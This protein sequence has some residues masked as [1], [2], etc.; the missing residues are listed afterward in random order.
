MDEWHQYTKGNKSA[1]K[2][3]V[4]FDE[5]FIRCN[6]LNA[7][8]Q[9]QIIFRFRAGLIGDLQTELL[10]RDVTE[11][12]ATYALVQDLYSLRSNYNIRSFDSKSS[13]FR[14]SSSSQFSRPS[15]Q[16][17]LHKNAIKGKSLELDNKSKDSEFLNVSSTTKCYK[18]KVIDI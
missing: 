4:K 18:C 14:T 8:G 16:N 7:E 3:V 9:A 15:T 12:K 13:A 1:K 6:T 5:F 2:Y 17:L 10:A 11:L